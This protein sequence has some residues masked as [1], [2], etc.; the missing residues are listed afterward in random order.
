MLRRDSGASFLIPFTDCKRH[1]AVD[2]SRCG[3]WLLA[4]IALGMT[5]ATACA[6]DAGSDGAPA[7]PNPLGVLDTSKF[8]DKSLVSPVPELLKRPFPSSADDLP[9]PDVP[10]PSPIPEADPQSPPASD[11]AATAAS[12][13]AAPDPVSPTPAAVAPAPPDPP[14]LVQTAPAP[15]TPAPATPAPATPAPAA[16]APSALAPAVLAPAILAPAVPAS[17]VL[18]PAAPAPTVPASTV[19]APAVQ[20]PTSAALP[21][22]SVAAPPVWPVPSPSPAPSAVPT[23]LPKEDSGFTPVTKEHDKAWSPVEQPI[24]TV[25]AQRFRRKARA[26]IAIGDI[27]AARALLDGLA[28]RHDPEASYLLAQ[29]YDPHKLGEWGV[30]GVEGDASRATNY[31]RRA[32]EGGYPAPGNGSFK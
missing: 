8:N 5:C 24:D 25:D 23:A 7:K 22:G 16:L 17:A 19:P 26:A 14:A 20:D 18:A 10:T 13:P 3:D 2:R 28:A 9:S 6:Q 12:A 30:V 27:A 15:A 31:Y 11:A 1:R 32:S 29:T 4:C 21:T